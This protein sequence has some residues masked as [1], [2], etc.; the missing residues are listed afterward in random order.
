MAEVAETGAPV[1]APVFLLLVAE[2]AA[3]SVDISFIHAA[4]KTDPGSEACSCAPLMN[5]FM[6]AACVYHHR[7]TMS[8]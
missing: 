3:P 5:S 1:R 7:F 8:Q 6:W 4:F 2:V